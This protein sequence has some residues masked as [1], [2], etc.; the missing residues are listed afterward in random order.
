[1]NFLADF[2]VHNWDL[3]ASTLR[4]KFLNTLEV[5][6]NSKYGP[7]GSTRVHNHSRCV[8]VVADLLY[9]ETHSWK[10]FRLQFPDL[11]KVMFTVHP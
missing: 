5:T 7:K 6:V 1:V 10:C 3:K 2:N 8:K 9:D 11:T 4:T